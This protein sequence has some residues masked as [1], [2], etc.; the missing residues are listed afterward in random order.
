[1]EN[2]YQSLSTDTKYE[3]YSA[4]TGR[5]LEQKYKLLI[6]DDE[7]W[8]REK[9]R[10]MIEWEKYSIECLEP[11]T[12]GEEVLERLKEEQ[13]DILITDINMPYVNGIELLQQVQ[14]DY[15][16]MITFVISGYDDFEYVKESFMAGSMN[17]LLKPVSKFDLINALAKALDKVSEK[18]NRKKEL[19]KAASMIQDREYSRF[20]EKQERPFTPGITMNSQVDFA[21]ASFL[22]IKIHNMHDISSKFQYDRALLSMEIKKKL[23]QIMK[24]DGKLIV[25]NH[26]YRS[27]E[28]M[29][30]T[31]IDKHEMNVWALKIIRFFEEFTSAP[32]TVVVSEPSYSLESLHQAYTQTIASLMTRKF[33]K[34]SQILGTQENMQA[35]SQKIEN[36][37]SDAMMQEFRQIL[38]KRK[39][40]QAKEFIR[41]NIAF[42]KKDVTWRYLEVRQVVKRL[43]NLIQDMY[44]E[45]M[46]AGDVIA[47]ENLTDYVDKSVEQLDLQYLC[48][49]LDDVVDFAMSI[50]GEEVVET[51][52][53]IIK[54]AAAYINEHYYEEL[55]LG[56]LAEQFHV[57]SSYFSRLFR[58][59]T[60]QNV[61]LYIAEKRIQKAKEYMKDEKR[62]LTEIAFLVGY[63]DYTYFNRVFRKIVGVN[64]REYRGGK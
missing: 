18:R 5:N 20:L 12:N 45:S 39:S 62:S 51:T 19:L 60:R 36:Y 38:K 10:R 59:E 11:A 22:L 27:N 58:Q 40:A 31:E 6:A 26:I 23:R 2:K 32:V 42:G 63:D 14:K 61:M 33:E 53:D 29:I 46:N 13:P 4:D 37:F 16:E 35:E 47:L 49:V 44:A 30:L 21:G 55:T 64:P 9:L 48:Q 41:E 8:T 28:F 57:E 54:Q 7:Y 52:R 1:M 34:V 3:T 43:L 50:R 24:D 56:S 17:Y 25:F 15:P